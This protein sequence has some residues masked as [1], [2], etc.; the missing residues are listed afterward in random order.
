MITY[1]A[2]LR[3]LYVC[4]TYMVMSNQPAINVLRRTIFLILKYCRC[5]Q[6]PTELKT[7]TDSVNVGA[8]FN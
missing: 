5:D 3:L 4:M 2:V 1:F 6:R 8:D 7:C